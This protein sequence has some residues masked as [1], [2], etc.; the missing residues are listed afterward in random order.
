LSSPW[1][2]F[3]RGVNPVYAQSG[4]LKFKPR[5]LRE[6]NRAFQQLTYYAS[7]NGWLEFRQDIAPIEADEFFSKYAKE[8]GINPAYAQSTAN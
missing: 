3:C 4:Q 8:P 7:D 5:Y 2:I 1:H 6:D